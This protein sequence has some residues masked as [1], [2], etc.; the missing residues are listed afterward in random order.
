[1]SSGEGDKGLVGGV[2]P[3][4]GGLDLGLEVAAGQEG[5]E[6]ADTVKVEAVGVGR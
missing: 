4:D 5:V 3:V 2:V 6:D 1:M